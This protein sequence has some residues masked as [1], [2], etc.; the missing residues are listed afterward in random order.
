MIPRPYGVVKRRGPEAL[1]KY[2]A[3]ERGPH[4][5]RDQIDNFS[6][7][8]AETRSTTSPVFWPRPDRD[9]PVLRVRDRALASRPDAPCAHMCFTNSCDIYVLGF[10]Q[11]D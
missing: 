4:F 3:Q 1:Y 9:P 2:W 6:S 8:L 11:H 5:G 10:W 7:I